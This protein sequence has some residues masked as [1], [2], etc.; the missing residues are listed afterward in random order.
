MAL[1]W[2]KKKKDETTGQKPP[3]K[4][5]GEATQAPPI[6]DRVDDAIGELLGRES[7]E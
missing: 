5:D 1:N 7:G 6:D 2:F 3:E 4:P